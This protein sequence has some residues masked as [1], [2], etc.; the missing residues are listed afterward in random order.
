MSGRGTTTQRKPG[1]SGTLFSRM[2]I[3]LT[4]ALASFFGAAVLAQ[5]AETS[6]T[7]EGGIAGTLNLPDGKSNVPAVVLLHGFGSSKDEV[8]G[9]YA[10]V[11]KALADRGVASLRIDFRGFGKS[12][13]DTGATSV[14]LQL[15]DAKLAVAFLAKTDGVDKSRIGTLGFSLGGA[16]AMLLAG[17]MPQDIKALATWSSVGDLHKDFLGLLTQAPFDRAEKEG[18]VGIDLGWRTIALKKGFFDSLSGHDLGASLAKYPGAYLAIAGSKD[19]SAAYPEAF[20]KLAAGTV[21]EVV[22]VPNG[23]HI[24]DVFNKDQTMAEGVIVKTAEWFAKTL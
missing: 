6:V 13:G 14:D 19:F 2:L 3:G 1:P 15:E 20:A 4:L 17:D 24:Y 16:V 18:I 23:D 11:A 8:G 10:R 22:I 21:K 12:D 9:M 5:A 7:L